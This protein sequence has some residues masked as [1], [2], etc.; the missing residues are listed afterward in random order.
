MGHQVTSEI[1]DEVCVG[2]R[3]EPILQDINNKDLPQE[4]NKS[5][6]NKK[7]QFCLLQTILEL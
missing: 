3:K 1:L 5:K 2:V 7:C 6:V 4:A